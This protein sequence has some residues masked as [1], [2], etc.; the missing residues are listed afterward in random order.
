MKFLTVL[1]L[2][3]LL[4]W[5][6][7]GP[8]HGSDDDPTHSI[9]GVEDLTPS[10][11]DTFINGAKHALVEF[12]APWCGH[13]K[14]M[15]PEFKKLGEKLN[16]DSKLNS[17][18]V[19]AKVNADEEE[20]KELATKYGVRG[21][22]TIKY[23]ARGKPV[24]QPEDYSG[25][26]TYDAFLSFLEDKIAG[27]TGFA[28]IPALDEL[29][30]DYTSADSTADLLGKVEAAVKKLSG[31]Q[32]STGALYIA[33]IK[34]AVTKGSDYFEKEYARLDSIIGSG[35]VG[36]KKLEEVARKSS[37]LSAFIPRLNEKPVPA[38]GSHDHDS[39]DH[40]GHDHSHDGHDHYGHDHAGHDH[41]DE[42]YA[43]D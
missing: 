9:E 3:C 20:N 32:L 42:M 30:K 16:A 37:V 40:S 8:S 31:E 22:P 11:F 15:T 5:A 41:D 12:Y 35:K 19:V 36:A 25:A 33:A 18:A 6:Q 13:C 24:D 7:P 38:A 4:L 23:F 10:S 34:K 17:R 14:R 39:H 27:D 29:V 2:T 1:A 21:F 26:R 43:E 28:R